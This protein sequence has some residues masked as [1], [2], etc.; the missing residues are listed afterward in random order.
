MTL[1]M[2]ALIYGVTGKLV[3]AGVFALGML[4]SW[5]ECATDVTR[6]R[7]KGKSESQIPLSRMGKN[8]TQNVIKP[9]LFAATHSLDNTQLVLSLTALFEVFLPVA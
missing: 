9:R 7:D 8:R 2:M 4:G 3:F 1:C 5:S 6:T